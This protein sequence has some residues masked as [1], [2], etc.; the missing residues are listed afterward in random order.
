MLSRSENELA[1]RTI[2]QILSS[3]S[4][5]SR[6]DECCDFADFRAFRPDYV[7]KPIAIDAL[8]EFFLTG[9]ASS[10]TS[11]IARASDPAMLMAL[12]TE[13][14]ASSG[15]AEKVAHHLLRETNHR[16]RSSYSE[17]LRTKA[18]KMVETAIEKRMSERDSSTPLD[19]FGDDILVCYI[20]GFHAGMSFV[21]TMTTYH[22]AECTPGNIIPSPALKRFLEL[23]NV[24]SDDFVGIVANE[25]GV[26]LT[27][28]TEGWSSFQVS[29]DQTRGALLTDE[30]IIDGIYGSPF[31]FT[32]LVAFRASPRFL[33]ER[34][35][36]EPMTVKGGM[37]GFH[38]FVNGSGNPQRFEGSMTIAASPAEFIVGEGRRFGFD[39][40]YGFGKAAFHSILTDA[41][42]ETPNRRP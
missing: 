22:G 31:G 10:V 9:S 16:V 14:L 12:A 15:L 28:S 8:S 4:I 11:T 1:E 40:A 29:C 32:P 30:A 39:E 33:I 37:I 25:T 42:A 35:W 19:A 7:T 18:M 23:I 2:K 21:S 5:R 6:I 3:P 27:T 34:D 24:S 20:P 41:I 38:N 36:T 17:T 26:N 13:R